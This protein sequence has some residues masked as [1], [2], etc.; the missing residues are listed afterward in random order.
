MKSHV[1]ANLDHVPAGSLFTPLDWLF[2]AWLPLPHAKIL[3]NTQAPKDEVQFVEFDLVF[4]TGSHFLGVQVEQK[5][6]MLKSKR[7]AFERFIEHY[8]QFNAI[9]ISRDRF[10]DDSPEFPK[11]I[12]S[13]DFLNFWSDVELPQG[14]PL[15]QNLSLTP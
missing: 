15:L 14:P 1:T 2:S 12:F 4:Y 8:P 10:P 3:V 5:G 9:S 7:E 13:Q 6:T 11:D